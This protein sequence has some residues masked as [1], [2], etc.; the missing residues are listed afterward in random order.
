MTHLKT[1][2]MCLMFEFYM[3]IFQNWPYLVVVEAL[4]HFWAEILVVHVQQSGV[5]AGDMFLR[6][7]SSRVGTISVQ[8]S[9]RR[10]SDGRAHDENRPESNKID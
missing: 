8:V 5:H 1:H 6:F 4:Q 10:L 9:V 3:G 2:D 7:T